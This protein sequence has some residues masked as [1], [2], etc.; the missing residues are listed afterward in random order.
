MILQLLVRLLKSKLD[1]ELA[2]QTPVGGTVTAKG[3][4]HGIKMFGG[5]WELDVIARRTE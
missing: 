1:A 2:A 4:A 3:V 5:R